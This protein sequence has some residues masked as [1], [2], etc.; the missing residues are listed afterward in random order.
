MKDEPHIFEETDN[1]ALL[2]KPHNLPSAPLVETDSNT[3]L[4]WYLE[5]EVNA[6]DVL[7]RKAI[8][9]GL[10]HR[11]DTGTAGFVLIAKN[12]QSYDKLITAQK[13]GYIKKTY[14]A[15][16]SIL[17]AH[18][19]ALQKKLPLSVISRFKAF[20]PGRREVR[21]L[22]PDMRGYN[23]AITDYETVIEHFELSG[24][25]TCEIICSLV[26]GY[27][28]QVRSHLSYLGFPILGDHLYNPIWK[29]TGETGSDVPLQLI[30]NG[31]SFPDPELELQVS[32]S[33]QPQD[34]TNR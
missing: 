20:G 29:D 4:G 11:L 1:W 26:R 6:R 27:R 9:H 32:F 28:H 19:S 18:N 23:E 34:K 22:F 25:N 12:Q 31:I 21:H 15:T 13:N 8:E 2:I 5:K 14:K 17:S 16:C 30:A 7:G 3:L 10:I 24:N 33:L